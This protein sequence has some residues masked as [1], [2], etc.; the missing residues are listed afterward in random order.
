M[1]TARVINEDSQQ[2][3]RLP[4]GFRIEGDEV[5]VH[6]VGR[7]LLLIP[8]DADRWQMLVDSLD[9]FTED[10]LRERGQP[11]EQERDPFFP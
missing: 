11:A 3:V 10:Y 5:G 4:A 1:K 8:S 7:S 6:Q 2:V 9:Q